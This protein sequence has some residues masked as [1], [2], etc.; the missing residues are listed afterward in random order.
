MNWSLV[1]YADERFYSKQKFITKYAEKNKIKSIAYTQDSL[2]T[3]DF[4]KENENILNDQDGVGYFLW[5]PYIILDA[6]NQMSEGD[7]LFY[8][9]TGDIFHPYL[10]NFVESVM[11]DD[12]CLLSLGGFPNKDWTKR[13]CFVL[14]DCDEK[15]YWDCTQLESGISF[16]KVC[17]QSKQVVS[18]WLEYCKD[19]RIVSDDDNVCGKENFPTFNSH[20]RDQSVLTNLAIKH[21]LSVVG[22]ELR[23]YIECNYDYWYE[24]N[25]KN[26]FNLGRPIDQLLISLREE[27]YA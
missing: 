6:L 17:D 18:E 19:R 15:D 26:G 21:G 10:I 20:R 5:K 1:T 3:T 27:L 11:E 4:Y 22:S 24:R 12:C 25:S 9:D 2:K 23:N 7:I 14:M 13:D 8:C 16:W